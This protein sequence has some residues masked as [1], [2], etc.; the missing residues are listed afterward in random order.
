MMAQHEYASFYED[1][2][3]AHKKEL[4]E[5]DEISRMMFGK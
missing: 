4:A 5:L 1:Q 3:L 2:I